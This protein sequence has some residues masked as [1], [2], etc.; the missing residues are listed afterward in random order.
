MRR[1]ALPLIFLAGLFVVRLFPQQPAAPQTAAQALVSISGVVTD[2]TGTV[3][4]NAKVDAKRLP[5]GPAASTTS[6][7]NGRYQFTNL[8]PGEYEITFTM[9]G[10]KSYIHKLTARNGQRLQINALLQVGN[11][12]ETI[13]V[14]ADAARR[15]KLSPYNRAQPV[16]ASAGEGGFMGVAVP[17]A[18]NGS[19]AGT[20]MG[21][22]RRPSSGIRRPSGPYNTEQYDI[23]VENEFSQVKNSPLS[24]FSTDVDTA[25]YSNVRRFLNEEQMPPAG[26]VRIEELINYFSYDYPVPENGKPVSMTTRLMNSPWNRGRQLLQIGLRTKPIPWENTPPCNLTFLIDVSGSMMPY[27]RLPLVKQ[28]LKMLVTQLRPEDQVAMV[29]YAGA[30]GVV[31]PPTKGSQ[32]QVILDAIDRLEAGGS[33]HG[34]AGIRLAYELARDTYRKKATN[35]VILATDGDFNI[36]VSSDSELVSLIEKERESG[37]FLSVLGVGRDNLKDS[38][39]EKLADHGN[40]NYSYLD[41]VS[42]ARRVLVQ[43]MGATLVTVAKD[44]KLQIEFNP[45]HVKAW[46]LIG[47]ENRLLRDED[48]NDDKKDA[49]DLG[50]GHQVTAFYE[51]IPAGSD[52]NT[53]GVDP[54]RYQKEAAQKPAAKSVHNE[55]AWLKL[56]YKEPTAGK[57]ELLEWP[58][59]SQAIAIDS[60]PADTR[61]AAAVA[62]YGIL[63]RGSKFKGDA[64]F[65]H[66]LQVASRAVGE[67]AAGPRAEFLDLLKRASKLTK[68]QP[69]RE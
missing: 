47:Y 27:D 54:L 45:E 6:D 28:G 31:L 57:S 34:S 38:R 50:A 56:R 46:R 32:A 5:N 7:A 39:M 51:L 9:P 37:I 30:A 23:Y 49:G 67:D 35:R 68:H 33:T 53:P 18:G 13:A 14:Q 69:E 58:V 15:E 3:I 40:G 29:V 26:S 20:V 10:F 65:G 8:A 36:G 52:E 1:L 24:T 43:Q 25:S 42:E 12:S 22:P 61:F 41:S 60:A 59:S 4:P 48:F 11:V 19:I 17:M 66:A 62:E 21:P 55:A 16:G 44:V 2:P 64:N 63:L